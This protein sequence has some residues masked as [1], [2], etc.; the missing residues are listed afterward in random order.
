MC[1]LTPGCVGP[2]DDV[3]VALLHDADA[4]LRPAVAVPDGTRVAAALVGVAHAPV[5]TDR[6]VARLI[7]DATFT[8]INELFL[9]NMASHIK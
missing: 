6:L 5:Q 4:K 3:F 7:R 8:V 9:S 2:E 1:I